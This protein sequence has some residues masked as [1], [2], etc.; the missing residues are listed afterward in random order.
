[1]LEVFDEV[2]TWVVAT[3]NSPWVLPAVAVLTVLDAFLVVVPSEAAV[4]ALGSLALSTGQPHP[5]ALVAVAALAAMAGDSLTFAMGRA[6]GGRLLDRARSPRV[7]HA[8]AWARLSLDRRAALVIFVARYIPFGRI[9]VNLT[10]G[11]TGFAYRRFLPI[12]ALAC[13]A[14]AIY[15]VSAGALVGVWLGRQPVL[16]VLVSI[17]VAITLGVLIDLV[18]TRWERRRASVPRPGDTMTG[19]T[20]NPPV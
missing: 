11:A 1:M 13:L 19:G 4:V 7:L 16:A 2:T 5:A 18:R 10:A 6:A 20:T 17:A 8:V 15:N 9:A 3:A 12:S 14:W